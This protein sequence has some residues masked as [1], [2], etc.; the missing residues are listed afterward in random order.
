[1]ANSIQL[2]SRDLEMKVSTAAVTLVVRVC[3]P[4]GGPELSQVLQPQP[5]SQRTPAVPKSRQQSAQS[6]NNHSGISY[7]VSATEHCY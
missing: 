2:R 5:L 7:F 3:M 4:E 6:L 1:M